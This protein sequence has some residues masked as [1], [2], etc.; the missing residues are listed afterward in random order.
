MAR[1][2]PAQV[3]TRL[4][5]D[6]SVMLGLR[7]GAL[8]A[9]LPF[10]SDEA[11]KD[12]R[13]ATPQEGN[14]GRA[15]LYL[16]EYRFPILISATRTI[17]SVRVKLDL[18]GGG[19]YPDS[20]PIVTC[21]GAPFPWSPHVHPASGLVCRGDGWENAKGKIL[22]AH[23]VVHVMRLFNFDE[24]YKEHY[25]GWN[26]PAIEY[27]RRVLGTRPLHPDLHYP[28]LPAKITH[29]AEDASNGF[30]PVG[31]GIPALPEARRFRPSVDAHFQP[32]LQD[33]DQNDFRP[34]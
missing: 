20:S 29:A 3:R 14:A 21:L 30:R 27:W 18:L 11:L 16:I 33:D 32:V 10:V 25:G 4:A 1:L 9:V 13:E 28:V 8:G 34:L 19:S 24:P 15:R 31:E 5:F 2:S 26:P 22:A 23:L 7:S 12:G 6:Y 17:P